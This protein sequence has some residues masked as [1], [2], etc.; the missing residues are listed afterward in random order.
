MESERARNAFYNTTVGVLLGRPEDEELRKVKR[1]LDER[2]IAYLFSP[3]RT[4]PRPMF[5]TRKSTFVGA[6]RIWSHIE[7][8]PATMP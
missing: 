1:L 6:E 7:S 5:L 3:D 2:R 4:R 8:I